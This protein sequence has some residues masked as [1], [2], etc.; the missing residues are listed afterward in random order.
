[1]QQSESEQERIARAEAEAAYRQG[2]CQ[3]MEE[4][5]LLV[6]QLVEL[7]YGKTEIK[8]LIAVFDDHFLAGWRA[9]NLD[10]RSAP[11]PFNIEVCREILTVTTGYDWIV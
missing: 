11:P 4:M 1:M 10:T 8:R 5:T 6:L 7:G 2:Y 3:G 9:G